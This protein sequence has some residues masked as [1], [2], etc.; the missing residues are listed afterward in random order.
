MKNL[1]D[2]DGFGGVTPLTHF[3]HKPPTEPTYLSEDYFE[4]YGCILDTAR[5][6]DMK[7]VFYDD[8]DFPSGTA[9]GRMAREYP[10]SL[11]KYLTRT[12]T[13]ECN[14]EGMMTVLTPVGTVTSTVLKNLETGEFTVVRPTVTEAGDNH[15]EVSVQVSAGTWEFQ[16]YVCAGVPGITLVDCL[17][18]EAVQQ[19]IGLT[20]DEFYRRFPEHFGTTIKMTFFDDLSL[21]YAPQDMAWTP[22]MDERFEE[23]YGCSPKLFYPALWEDIG[24]NTAAARC[25]L[26]GLRNELFA[27]GYPR[28]V[29]EWAEKRNITCAGHPAG[30][31]RPN[32]LQATG[33]AILFYKYM[34]VTLVDYIIGLGVGEDGFKAPVSSAYNFDHPI[35]VCE[36]YGAFS[37]QEQNTW[38]MLFRAAMQVYVRGVNYLIAHGSWWDPDNLAI[39]PEVSWRNP[40]MAEGLPAY[41]QWVA[42]CEPLLQAGRHIADIGVVYPIDDLMSHY[43]AG[44]TRKSNG[45]EPI[46]G[47][48][49]YDISPILTGELKHDF[50]FLHPEIIDERCRVD[51]N[52]FLLDN[53]NNWERYRVILLP[54][55]RTI[56]LSNLKKINTFLKN[57]GI[58]IA[59]SFLPEK[60][61]EFGM[62]GEVGKLSRIMFGESG[63]GIFVQSPTSTNLKEAF[64]RM[65]LAWDVTFKNAT[66]ITGNV[67]S[68]SYN[69]RDNG[70][71]T[72]TDSN[73]EFSYIHRSAPGMEIYFFANSSKTDVR[74]EIVLRGH[75]ELELWN[76]HSGTTEA[77]PSHRDVQH[78]EAVTKCNISLTGISSIFIIGRCT[79]ER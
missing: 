40:A 68:F 60:S 8:C 69:D 64:G 61:A 75:M 70:K 33:D 78:G 56:R 53:H 59:T 54:A 3:Q 66:E 11:M 57:G 10:Q 67:D 38:T 15:I 6:L 76:P 49:Y 77:V 39:C 14:D 19:F 74:A 26:F 29:Q 23:R 34:G 65:K 20:Y 2:I 24:E 62:D 37:P 25:A 35:V 52:E 41:N 79:G 58:V 72:Y 44:P 22:G 71:V 30:S 47:S 63:N 18:P 4:M 32:P 50:T 13:R 73:R 51:G 55:C 31:Y 28:A 48:D 12:T 27:G 7:V 46:P 17:D 5:E 36:I 42:R 9:G 21:S 45:R 1:R 16:T 43:Y